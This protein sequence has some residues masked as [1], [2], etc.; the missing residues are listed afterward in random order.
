MAQ[1]YVRPSTTWTVTTGRSALPDW[2]RRRRALRVP[3]VIYVAPQH[4]EWV[5]AI[6][7]DLPTK[8]VAQD[9]DRHALRGK[10]AAG[11]DDPRVGCLPGLD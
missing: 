8:I 1:T 2:P 9:L 11:Y 6:R 7:K 4:V 10:P 3:M 5:A